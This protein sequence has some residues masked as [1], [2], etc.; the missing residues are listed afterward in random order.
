MADPVR[1]RCYDILAES[2]SEIVGQRSLVYV[3]IRQAALNED[4]SKERWAETMFSQISATS[5]RRI[6]KTAL[7][8]ATE[9]QAQQNAAR[10]EAHQPEAVVADLSR[11]FGGVR[12]I[13]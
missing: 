10:R 11:L 3:A 9:E 6:R 4:S 5:R 1:K 13:Y 7:E 8:R 12:P 2:V